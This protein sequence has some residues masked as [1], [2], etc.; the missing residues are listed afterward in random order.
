MQIG[1]IN[2]YNV[3]RYA[4][5]QPLSHRYRFCASV[6]SFTRLRSPT[7]PNIHSL[8]DVTGTS[9]ALHAIS[10]AIY[11]K[12][13]TI[14]AIREANIGNRHGRRV[15]VNHF[16]LTEASK[17]FSRYLIYGWN[18][19]SDEGIVHL[20]LKWELPY[21]TIG[22]RKL[23]FVDRE[24]FVI[25]FIMMKLRVCKEKCQNKITVKHN[26]LMSVWHYVRRR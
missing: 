2:R 9:N 25:T 20:W 3:T 13:L 26:E 21:R 17:R 11:A 7:P 6:A 10:R 1:Y 4:C 14:Y 24:C 16:K 22:C 12:R 18:G 5:K 23:L 19:D 15:S 8:L